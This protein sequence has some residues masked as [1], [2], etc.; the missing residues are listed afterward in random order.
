MYLK[1]LL[2]K[3]KLNIELRKFDKHINDYCEVTG[4][5]ADKRSG[6]TIKKIN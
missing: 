3:I 6:L 5:Y 2:Q 1:R 4:I